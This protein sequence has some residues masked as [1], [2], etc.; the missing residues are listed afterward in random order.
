[1]ATDSTKTLMYLIFGFA[2]G[3]FMFWQGFAV[4]NKKKLIEN[5]PTSKTRSVAIGLTEVKG[6]AEV[7]QRTLESPFSKEP[8][9]YY[10]YEVWQRVSSGKRSYWKTI[11]KGESNDV[12]YLQD[13]TGKILID[14]VGAETHLSVDNKYCIG[15]L[16]NKNVDVFMVAPKGPG[17]LV[18]KMYEEGKGVPCLIA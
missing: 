1:M 14:P 8:C 9:V 3:C 10:C 16:N 2:S 5:I 17:A 13:E 15:M 6:V 4:R 18:R 11:A 7:N 12:F